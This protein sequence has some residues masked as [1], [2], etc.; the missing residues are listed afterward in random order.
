[1]YIDRVTKHTIWFYFVAEG[2]PDFEKQKKGG[3]E[4]DS[5]AVYNR[6]S[7]MWQQGVDL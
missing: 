6:F 1:L 4:P 7:S 2:E 3:G 5:K